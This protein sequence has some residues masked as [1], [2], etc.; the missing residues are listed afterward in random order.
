MARLPT[1]T[2]YRLLVELSPVMVWRAGLDTRC[3]YFNEIW[4]SFTGRSLEQEMGDGWAEGVHL[5]DLQR[6][7]AH[8]LDHFHRRE[9]FEMEYRLRRNDGTYRWIFDR[10]VPFTDD[11][12][13]FAG[14][15]G[16][17]VDVDDRR[18]AAELQQ[19]HNRR[20][21]ALAR[22]F[23]TWILA[24]VSHDIRDPLNAIQL[25]ALGLRNVQDP[26]GT[27]R[28]HADIVSRGVNRIQHIVGDLLDLSREREG[29]GIPI[30]PKPADLQAICRQ[31]IEE[32]EAI[33]RDRTIT[34]DCD[35][36]GQGQWDEH[37]VLQAISNLTSNAVQ[38]GTPGSPVRVRLSGDEQR[39]MVEVR[40]EGVI[41]KA[42]LPRIFE[43]FRSGRHHAHRG[44]GLG[45]GLFIAN[46]VARAHGG[47][48]EV[49][50]ANGAT[51][52]RLMLPRYTATLAA[53]L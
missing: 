14:F 36:D 30:E 1:S 34:F 16:S 43:P 19:Q 6:C 50:S 4:L 35:A 5:D 12:D 28:K 31:I 23:E 7:M 29:A 3:D 45:L 24:I 40:N 9:A 44:D 42:L 49:D 32:L 13:A 33:A 51:S 22:D 18:K 17:C 39:V 11:T 15:I 8:Y 41:P 46:A 21:L 20:Q 52:F 27:V 37:R 48:L 10:G 38:H 26:A 25:A 47:G 2:E 53:R